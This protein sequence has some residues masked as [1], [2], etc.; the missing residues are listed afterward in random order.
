MKPVTLLP[1]GEIVNIILR[2]RRWASALGS[3]NLSSPV[4]SCDIGFGRPAPV[5]LSRGGIPIGEKMVTRQFNKWANFNMSTKNRKRLKKILANQAERLSDDNE[6][7]EAM[8][9]VIRS[10][11]KVPD[12]I[13][14]LSESSYPQE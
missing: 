4:Q 1:S 5:G 12:D 10:L 13:L 9:S 2:S 6:M 3:R 14:I 8:A 7:R 11:F